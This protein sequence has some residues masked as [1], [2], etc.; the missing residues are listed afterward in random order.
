MPKLLPPIDDALQGML[1]DAL[2]ELLESAGYAGGILF[3][4]TPDRT[5]AVVSAMHPELGLEP[6][7]LVR[8]ALAAMESRGVLRGDGPPP[9]NG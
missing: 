4:L 6:I 5:L 7:E 3:A 9:I 1:V 2:T 8:Q